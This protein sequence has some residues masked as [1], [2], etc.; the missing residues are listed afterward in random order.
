MSRLLVLVPVV[1]FLFAGISY[2]G[3]MQIIKKDGNYAYTITTDKNQPVT[4]ENHI[5]IAITDE[6][7]APVKDAKVKIEY[8]MA[9]MPAM[10]YKLNAGL[11]GDGYEARLDL[12]MAGR[13]KVKVNASRG[14]RPLPVARFSVDAH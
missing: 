14:G 11:D 3:G 2:A 13:W 9:S 6:S 5:A 12:P 7:G 4:G 1:V 10:N 8:F